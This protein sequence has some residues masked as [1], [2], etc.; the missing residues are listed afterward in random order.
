MS[1]MKT[2]TFCFCFLLDSVDCSTAE[3]TKVS[4]IVEKNQRVETITPTPPSPVET[5]I[6]PY[7]M[8]LQQQKE[9][10]RIWAT[11]RRKSNQRVEPVNAAEVTPQVADSRP[12]DEIEQIR[13]LQQ[14][15]DEKSKECEQ[16]FEKLHEKDALLDEHENTSKVIF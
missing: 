5:T 14:Q 3:R 10:E 2:T 13:K 6:H 7:E 12:T 15:L 1:G 4:S 16:L 8:F 9:Q 11:E